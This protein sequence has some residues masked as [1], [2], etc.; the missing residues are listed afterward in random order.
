[1][2]TFDLTKITNIK[3]D[4]IDHKY[5]P[6]YADAWICSADYEGYEMTG[7]QLER[8]NDEEPEFVHEKL[9]EHLY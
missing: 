8:L 7:D 3:F 2:K 6:D 4:G 5:H 1:M 9:I